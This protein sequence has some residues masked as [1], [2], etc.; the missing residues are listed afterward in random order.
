MR[1]AFLGSRGI[2]ARYSG[3]ET[4]YEQLAV[5]LVRRGHDVTVYNRSHFIKDARGTYEGTRL[6]SLTSIRTKHLDTLTH[7]FV[8]SLHA[9]T[10]GFDIAYYCIV[11]NSPLVWLPRIMGTKTL[12]NVDGEDWAREKWGPFAR[13][14][15]YRCERIAAR[16]A[17]VLISDAHGI[18]ERYRT[19]HGVNTVFAPYGANVT[20]TDAQDVLARWGLKSRG[21]ILY[22]GRFVPENA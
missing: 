12:L 1:I 17:N 20:R 14:Y 18:Q 10:Q 3:F 6:V 21:Y 19:V 13:W 2:P 22:V 16:T 11:G 9:L 15:Q 5:R 7:T 8:S 4:F